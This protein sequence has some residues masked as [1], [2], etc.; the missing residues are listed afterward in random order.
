MWFEG[1]PDLDPARLVFINYTAFSTKMARLRGWSKRGTSCRM[2]LPHRHWDTTTFIG[3]LRLSDM[4]APMMLTRPMTDEWFAA[5]SQQILASSQAAGD[6]V[7]LDNHPVRTGAAARDAV[8]AIGARLLF[9]PPYSPD[10][11]PI[12]NIFSKIKAW[13]KRAAPRTVETLQ[14]VVRAAI[15]DV[16]SRQATKCFTAAGYEPD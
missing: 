3:G 10:F 6:I 9:L 14:E 15:D 4:T 8:E 13:I 11:D 16:C 1:R 12:G 2:P 7:A 5:Y